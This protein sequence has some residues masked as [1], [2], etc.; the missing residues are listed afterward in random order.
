MLVHFKDWMSSL[1]MCQGKFPFLSSVGQLLEQKSVEKLM[2]TKS[3][4]CVNLYLEVK[5]VIDLAS[6]KV[7]S[8]MPSNHH[9]LVMVQLDDIPY[10][11]TCSLDQIKSQCTFQ[12]FTFKLVL[13]FDSIF[14]SFG[15]WY[16]SN[17]GKLGLLIYLEKQ[18]IRPIFQ[19]LFLYLSFKWTVCLFTALRSELWL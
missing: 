6:S 3:R 5:E 11:K 7:Y 14:I 8:F 9:L 19:H 16:D 18:E 1:M 13:H 17:K 2:E 10:A 15:V 4:E 12:K